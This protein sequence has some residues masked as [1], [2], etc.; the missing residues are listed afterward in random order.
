MEKVEVA[1]T[2]ANLSRIDKQLDDVEARLIKVINILY[3][4]DI[5]DEKIDEEDKE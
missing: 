2:S 3:D 1:Y 4:Q 5:I